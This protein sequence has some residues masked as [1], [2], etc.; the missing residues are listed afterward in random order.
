MRNSAWRLPWRNEMVPH[1]VI[2]VVR[3]CNITCRA[4]INIKSAIPP[5]SLKVVES[6]LDKL[7]KLR[8]LSSVSI[9]GGEVSMHPHLFEIIKAA[10]SHG[11][12][13][14]LLSNGLEV[15]EQM[16][17]RLK[18]AGLTIIYFHIERGQ[19]RRDLPEEHT[20]RDINRLRLE[21]ATIAAQTG[22][23]VG[24]TVT[25]Y[26]TER[27]DVR[28]TIDLVLRTPEINYLLITLYRDT[29][30]IESLRGNIDDGF[31]GIGTPPPKETRQSSREIAKWMREEFG[32]EPFGFMGTN[33]DSEDPRWLSYLVGAVYNKDGS[34]YVAHVT[35]SL[36]EKGALAFSRL[37]KG[38]YPMYL[39]QN[40]EQFRRQLILNGMLGGTRTSAHELAERARVPGARL[41]AKRLLYQNLAEL[42]ADGRLVYCRWCP[43]AV[44]K[45]GSLVPVCVADRVT[46]E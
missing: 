14:E 29:S 7:L 44:L 19:R 27:E 30:G 41:T 26:P 1:A 37:L 9:F 11:I 38:R 28:D 12:E 39:E 23:D 17:A 40:P 46:S 15:D 2:D 45:G 10:R 32:F 42:T 13:V 25:A 5:K 8:R 3:D 33:L 34:H 18:E 6:E 31:S 36:L 43:D 35:P 4:C 22:L 20:S 24:M 21:K 16:C